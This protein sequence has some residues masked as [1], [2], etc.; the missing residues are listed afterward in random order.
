MDRPV[1]WYIFVIEIM[2]KF[3]ESKRH[4]RLYFHSNEVNASLQRFRKS[5]LRV[6]PQSNKENWKRRRA[7][8]KFLFWFTKKL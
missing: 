4:P 1:K 2:K 3:H 5:R 7:S 8:V 6:I